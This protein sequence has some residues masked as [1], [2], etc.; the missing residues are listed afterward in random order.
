MKP[1]DHV[2][3][4]RAPTY[5]AARLGRSRFLRH[6]LE[7]VAAMLVGMVALGAA[8]RGV[9]ALAGLPYPTRYPELTALEMALTMSAGMGMAALSIG[10][11]QSAEGLAGLSEAL[12]LLPLEYLVVAKLRRRQASWTVLVAGFAL[13]VACGCWT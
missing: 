6:Y 10:G 4:P 11:S 1:A 12:M 7:M 9:L 13:I 5:P 3:T 2:R 8:L